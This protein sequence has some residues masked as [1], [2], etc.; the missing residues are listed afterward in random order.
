MAADWE[1]VTRMEEILDG[2]EAAAEGLARELDRMD[3]L[4]DGMT[5]L[6]QYYGSEDWHADRAA[7]KPA[8]VKAGVLSEDAV[9][10]LITRLR[11]LSFRMLETATDILKNR[12]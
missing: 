10:D 1:R 12:I 3:A 5:A 8:E 4:R 11:D 2:S 9:Y 6:F 7:D